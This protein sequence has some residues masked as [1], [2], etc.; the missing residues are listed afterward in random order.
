MP[1]DYSQRWQPRYWRTV[2]AAY[3]RAPFFEHYAGA[4][5]KTLLTRYEYLY[6][7]NLELLTDCLR[8]L[9]LS[10]E[11]AESEVYSARVESGTTDLRDV[12]N[13][14]KPE[15]TDTYYRSVPYTQVFGAGFEKNLSVI[16]LLFCTG[17]ESAGNIRASATRR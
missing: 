8:L 1:I 17:P 13:V 6:Q 15:L 4:I 11:L 7:L 2:E 10:V 5:K 16:D 9:K 12:I 14:R 3:G